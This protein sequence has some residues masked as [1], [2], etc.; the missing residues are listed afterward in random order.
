MKRFAS[1]FNVVEV[2]TVD[3][4]GVED[5]GDEFEFPYELFVID[6]DTAVFRASKFIQE[7]YIIVKHNKSGK[8]K[9][10]R[11]KTEFYGHFKKK[12]GGWLADVNKELTEK[13]KPTIPVEDFTITE[14]ERLIDE[15]GD[16][17]EAGIRKFDEFIGSV[18]KARLAPTYR[19]CIGGSSN[20]RYDLAET[21]PYKGERP[22]K[23]IMFL[24]I[25]EAIIS[26]YK[27]KV[28]LVDGKECDDELSVYGKENVEEFR[29]S[30]KWKYV[31][32]Y[33][34]KD[35]K[36]IY[37]P[38]INIDKMDEGVVLRTP[39]ECAK[40]YATQCLI[41]DKSVDNI[42]GL[43]NLTEELR[44]KYNIRKGK[45]LGATT[46]LNLLEPCETTKEVFERVVEAYK[47]YYGVELFEFTNY[48]GETFECDWLDRL[49]EVAML[50][51]MNPL[52]NPLDYDIRQTLDK[53]GVAYD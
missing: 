27:S 22:S 15:I 46:A 24:E 53:L 19:L 5:V 30:S 50:V 9:E 47:S 39:L 37:S 49:N 48:K 41:G 25:K 23:P 29:K 7:D 21:L 32:G 6:C 40:C 12:S 10:F 31:L 17:L 38:S 20:F 44:T 28:H 11:N 52:D 13:G 2:K 33:I 45:S 4:F 35:L 16:H 42:A 43:P 1:G 34:D 36:M 14:H 51:Y 8:E 26:K 18:K 3:E